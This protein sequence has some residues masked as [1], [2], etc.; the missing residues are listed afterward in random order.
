MD[1]DIMGSGLFDGVLEANPATKRAIHISTQTRTD[2]EQS[3]KVHSCEY[4]GRP[5][6][7]TL[8]TQEHWLARAYPGVFL[9]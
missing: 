3:N 2:P 1:N 4:T 5:H 6:A 7:G 8:S 9:P